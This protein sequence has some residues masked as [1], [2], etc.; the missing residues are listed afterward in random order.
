MRL[1]IINYPEYLSV[2]NEGLQIWLIEW[3]LRGTLMDLEGNFH[4]NTEERDFSVDV[5]F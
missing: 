1:V 2:V 5:D 3:L 4:K